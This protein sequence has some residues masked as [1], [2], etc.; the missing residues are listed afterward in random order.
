MCVRVMYM[1]VRDFV[2]A[3][4]SVI[5]RLNVGTVFPSIICAYNW[6][7]YGLFFLLT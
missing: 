6:Y 7:M 2:V 4:V 3:S 5:F 1:C